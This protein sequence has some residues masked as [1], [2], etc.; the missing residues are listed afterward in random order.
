MFESEGWRVASASPA[1]AGPLTPL[2]DAAT[3][4]PVM[5]R[6]LRA[7]SGR[8]S[9]RAR[10]TRCSAKDASGVREVFEDLAQ[11]IVRAGFSP[12]GS[13]GTVKLSLA[14]ARAAARARQSAKSKC[15]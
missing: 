4:P 15:C 2:L 6:A 14:D 13:S 11:L 1:S 12:S 7:D 3:A 8:I 5:L 10:C 9:T